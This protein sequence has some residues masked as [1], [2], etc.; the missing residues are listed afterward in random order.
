MHQQNAE[1]KDFITFNFV[2]LLMRIVHEKRHEK[3]LS[4]NFVL[5]LV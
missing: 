2:V 3:R 1:G 5:V 4:L